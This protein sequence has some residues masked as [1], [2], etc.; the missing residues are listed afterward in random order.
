MTMVLSLSLSLC[1]YLCLCLFRT[2]CSYILLIILKSWSLNGKL[3][4][5]SGFSELRLAHL[6]ARP[7]S[8]RLLCMIVTNT[9]T[10]GE[11][12]AVLDRREAAD[13]AHSLDMDGQRSTHCHGTFCSRNRPGTRLPTGDNV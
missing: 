9:D 11:V 2:D 8:A 3:H 1:L 7:G 13:A 5:G 10:V 4:Q 12:Q 6:G